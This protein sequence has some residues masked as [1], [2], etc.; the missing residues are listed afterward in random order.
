MPT[1]YCDDGDLVMDNGRAITEYL[2]PSVSATVTNKARDDARLRAYSEINGQFL[3]NKTKVPA[4]HISALVHIEKDLAISYLMTGSFSGETS[5]VSDWVK[6]YR[7]RALGELKNLKWDAS[8][9]DP[10]P[11]TQNVGNGTIAIHKLFEEFVRT[12]N[13]II[14]ALGASDFSVFGTRSGYLPNAKLALR[15]PEY[16]WNSTVSDYGLAITSARRWVEFPFH[17]TISA[18]GTAFTQD[19][20]FYF[21]TYS[22]NPVRNRSRVI[23]M[24]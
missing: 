7:D 8:Y 20:I 1:T 15:W 24:A 17:M 19:D 10:Q 22:P 16:D 4:T 13:W 2:D 23:K 18:G 11:N 12:E 21:T 9:T 14:R 5:N 3:Q 6:S